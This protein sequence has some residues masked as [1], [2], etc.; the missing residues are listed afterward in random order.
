[1]LSNTDILVPLGPFGWLTSQ[2]FLLIYYALDNG[3]NT[4]GIDFHFANDTE[5]SSRGRD[6]EN[7]QVDSVGIFDA[8]NQ[9]RN[10]DNVNN[11]IIKLFEKEF[12]VVSEDGRKVH[13]LQLTFL[14]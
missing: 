4:C 9:K 10:I 6:D 2:V 1:M 11:G 7:P 8:E 5:E 3:S 13:S 14:V 12:K